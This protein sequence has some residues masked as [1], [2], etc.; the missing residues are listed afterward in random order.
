MLPAMDF[1]TKGRLKT[2]IAV[3]CL[4]QVLIGAGKPE[5][6]L[7]ILAGLLGAP[8]DEVAA[9]F[10]TVRSADPPIDYGTLEAPLVVQRAD[11]GWGRPLISLQV[12]KEGSG[13]AQERP[14]AQLLIDCRYACASEGAARAVVSELLARYG[15]PAEGPALAW[16]EPGFSIHVTFGDP[17]V[18]EALLGRSGSELRRRLPEGIATL[19]DPSADRG[20]VTLEPP[21]RPVDRMLDPSFDLSRPD[22]AREPEGGLRLHPARILIRITKEE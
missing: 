10:G 6:S 5:F 18:R 11:L 2:G 1:S 20:P 8:A 15:A 12:V 14:V 19:I 4:A 3:A 13:Q 22:L 17:R 21:V 9:L 7:G 16:E